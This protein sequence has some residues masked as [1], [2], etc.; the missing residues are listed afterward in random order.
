VCGHFAEVSFT[1]VFGDEAVLAGDDASGGSETATESCAGF[2][3]SPQAA[4]A[5]SAKQQQLNF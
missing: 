1:L 5:N 3:E 2:F 4:V